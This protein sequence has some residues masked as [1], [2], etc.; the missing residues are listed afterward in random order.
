M[1]WASIL[2]LFD[3]K[4][5]VALLP[6][7][8][9]C[10]ISCG[11]VLHVI[12]DYCAGGAW[13]YCNTCNFKGDMIELASAVWNLDVATTITKLS[14]SGVEFPE[15]RLL[16]I[17]VESYIHHHVN[18]RK[19]IQSFWQQWRNNIT[20]DD[21]K[22]LRALQQKLGIRLN[23]DKERWLNGPGLFVG[24]ANMDAVKEC[25]KH[26][27]HSKIN[28]RYTQLFS[29]GN[30]GELLI[31]PLHVLPGRLK[32]F[33]FIG[34]E[35]KSPGDVLSKIIRLSRAR[36]FDEK[37]GTTPLKDDDAGIALYDA[38]WVTDNELVVMNDPVLALR[39]QCWHLQDHGQPAPV[40]SMYS[41][42]GFRTSTSIWDTIPNKLIFWG[43]PTGELFRHARITNSR[44]YVH[45][46]N[47]N[48]PAISF[49]RKPLI[50]WLEAVNRDARPWDEVLEEVLSTLPAS[51]AEAILMGMKLTS[52]ELQ[53]LLK[54]CPNEIQNSMVTCENTRVVR[55]I[56][57][58]D[59]LIREKYGWV[60]E[61]HD[62]EI[63]NGILRIE[64]VVHN[65]KKNKNYFLGKI[66]FKGKEIPFIEKTEIVEASPFKW[67]R[68]LLLKE[69]V[70]FFEYLSEWEKYAITIAGKF[71]EPKVSVE[72]EAIG[73]DDKKTCFVFPQY[74]ITN[75][76]Q[77]LDIPIKTSRKVSK[78]LDKFKKPTGLT[79]EE[80]TELS[81]PSMTLLW[82]MATC[83]AN[84]LLAP[85]YNTPLKGI[86]LVGPG[87]HSTGMTAAKVLCCT[88]HYVDTRSDNIAHSLN[89]VC[90]DYK[91]PLII[92]AS[93]KTC[94]Q[95]ID[96]LSSRTKYNCV[97]ELNWHMAQVLATRTGWN[98]IEAE[99]SEAYLSITEAA[100]K[101]LPL[102]LQYIAKTQFELPDLYVNKVMCSTPLRILRSIADWFS[103]IGG[104]SEIVLTAANVLSFDDEASKHKRVV[105]RLINLLCSYF[106]DG[107]I[108][109]KRDGYVETKEPLASLICLPGKKGELGKIFIAKAVINKLLTKSNA[110]QLDSSLV[111]TALVQT[112]EGSDE[113]YG[114]LP[115]WTIREQ[116]WNEQLANWENNRS[117]KLR[118]K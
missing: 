51:K 54:S 81:Q 32:G 33:I 82:A 38:R 14:L 69:G 113:T 21:N 64:E 56:I 85:V 104:D 73:W 70:G 94:S 101:I 36:V 34:R 98:L 74:V 80:I 31:L 10:P 46:F 37:S 86:G 12:H 42:A 6:C 7:K 118:V 107:T 91:W 103:S 117:Y 83:I 77:I 49:T 114:K 106:D 60:L 5:E 59:K 41:N 26:S 100:R 112:N 4:P 68:N 63:C 115:G 84:N 19:Q 22:E 111:S 72:T 24:G 39:M 23:L 15:G 109:M 97:V 28:T 35:A 18:Y 2:T 11:G 57:V 87:A 16:P 13:A 76:G 47:E 102:F 52:K 58:Q 29:G 78:V 53:D 65:K 79:V 75:N 45:G 3:R 17:N 95:W 88:I 8:V 105:Q 116:T 99:E 61:K 50:E 20:L 71:H 30:W 43:V 96:W 9:Q 66:I 67:M 48:G 93:G 1:D 90:S 108:D 44:V 25:F 92:K 89:D 27:E 110:P 40:V 62:Q 55:S